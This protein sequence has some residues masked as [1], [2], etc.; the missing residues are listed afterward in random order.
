MKFWKLSIEELRKKWL[1][2]YKKYGISITNKVHRL[3]D[4]VEDFIS[5]TG[6]S[7]GRCND[8]LIEAV[9]SYMNKRLVLSPTIFNYYN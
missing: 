7:L 2:L 4:H 9:H 1:N 3:I 5:V 6:N 8:Q